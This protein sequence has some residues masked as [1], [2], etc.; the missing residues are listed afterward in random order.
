MVQPLVL[1]PWDKLALYLIGL[2]GWFFRGWMVSP[3]LSL[4]RSSPVNLES[5]KLGIY[6]EDKTKILSPGLL[7]K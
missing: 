6:Q 4:V 7:G 3:L 5:R 1:K 2:I